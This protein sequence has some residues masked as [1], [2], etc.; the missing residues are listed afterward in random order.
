M[1]QLIRTVICLALAFTA[2]KQANL[3][4]EYEFGVIVN[5]GITV[6]GQKFIDS[7]GRQVILSG[8]NKV[9]KNPNDN[10][11][12][13]D[14][15]E[16]YR[17]MKEWGFN[18]IRLGVI[19]DGIEPEP[20]IYNEQ[21]LDEIE[22]RVNWAAE[23]GLYVMLDMHQDLY[24][25]SMSVKDPYSGDGAPEWATITDGLPHH[26]GEIWSDSYI[27][28]PAVQKAFD[29][30]WAN[31]PASDGIGLQDHYALMWKH[32]AARF[33]GNSAV[34]GYDIMNEPFNGS[35]GIPVLPAILREFAGVY[36]EATGTVQDEEQVMTMW[37]SEEN[38]MKAFSY[39]E[40]ADVYA[41]VID[42][43]T[44][45]NQQFE[46]NEL[47][48]FYQK[49]GSSIRQ[50]DTTHILFLEHG[51]FANTGMRSALEPVRH[52]DG[53]IDPLVGYAAHGYDLLTDT[54]NV[55]SQGTERI[56]FIFSRINETGKRM[57]SPVL[58]G[59]WG[60]FG[61]NAP[62]LVAVARNIL[63]LFEEYHFSN[64][65]WT[66]FNNIQNYSFFTG[67]IIRPYPQ[68]ISGTLSSYS[69]SHE[70]GDFNMT[71]QED[72]AVK[73]PTVIFIPSLDR[74]VKE[75][76]RV[77]PGNDRIIIETIKG[78]TNG[79]IVISPLGGAQERNFRLNLSY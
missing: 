5:N 15:A 75:S 77:S 54:K 64:T 17:Q 13:R 24:G 20:G 16:S 26:K 51:Y 70:T 7:Y 1:K 21:Y 31:T 11:L 57:N 35:Q 60:A 12:D 30:F 27:I 66:Y 62:G 73:A 52:P 44:E 50:V 48:D 43:A 33:A 39:I 74:L 61:G 71:W 58:I 34:I 40:K 29:H 67:A 32:I 9:N 63:K 8:I 79:Y 41:R 76:V 18:V 72:P 14:S 55:G 23:N 69:F 78:T 36:A 3:P 10:Y 2:C 38:R 68:F 28:S 37:A 22:K 49:V 45:I 65:F 25:V 42:A 53:T 56:S 59:E 47:R 4:K 19:W 46:R 6:D